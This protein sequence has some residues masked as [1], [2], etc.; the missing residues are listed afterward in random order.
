MS[1]HRY[2]KSSSPEPARP[3]R[4]D[5]CSSYAGYLSDEGA[6]CQ[7]PVRQRFCRVCGQSFRATRLDDVRVEHVHV[8]D[9]GQ[10]V[11]GNVNARSHSD[12]D[13]SGARKG[14]RK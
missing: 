12:S 11:I 13:V 14:G 5:F 4:H 9:G 2:L 1:S 8:S 10:A 6:E 7:M 3:D